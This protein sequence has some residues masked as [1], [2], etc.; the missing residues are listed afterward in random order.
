VSSWNCQYEANGLCK[1][2]DGAYCRP[3]MKGCVLV[4]KVTF[5]DGEVPSPVWPEGARLRR[6]APGEPPGEG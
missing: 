5:Q 3:G 4:G 2:L 1:K 6:T